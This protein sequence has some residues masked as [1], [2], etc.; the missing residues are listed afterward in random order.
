M[1]KRIPIPQK[2]F[3]EELAFHTG[4][5]CRIVVN[6]TEKT[7]SYLNP[8]VKTSFRKGAKASEQ[9]F[10]KT[11]TTVTEKVSSFKINSEAQ[12]RNLQR[13][14]RHKSSFHREN[15]E[16]DLTPIL[17]EIKDIAEISGFAKAMAEVKEKTRTCE[18]DPI[19]EKIISDLES[20]PPVQQEIF[21]RDLVKRLEKNHFLHEFM[22]PSCLEGQQIIVENEDKRQEIFIHCLME[23]IKS[24]GYSEEEIKHFFDVMRMISSPIDELFQ[25]YLHPGSFKNK[26]KRLWKI[27]R[28]GF[29][30]VKVIHKVKKL[31]PQPIAYCGLQN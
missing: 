21:L 18:H 12:G 30:V 29:K 17:K 3:H 27:Q 1:K 14:L 31:E 25:F 24:L 15:E 23:N 22:I 8:K 7:V 13:V 11:V 9:F 26:M 20:M 16:M 2:I 28:I 5:L 19:I 4:K 6:R 10:F